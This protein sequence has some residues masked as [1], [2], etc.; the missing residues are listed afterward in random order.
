MNLSVRC[1][2][3]ILLLLSL[4]RRQIV[5]GLFNWSVFIEL[6]SLWLNLGHVNLYISSLVT[7]L[8]LLLIWLNVP[9]KWLTASG[10]IRPFEF[11]D[12]CVDPFNDAVLVEVVHTLRHFN[13]WKLITFLILI[14]ELINADPARV[15]ILE[16][17]RIFGN[18]F[19]VV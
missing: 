6:R 13:D 15:S 9:D 17:L 5:P 16:C 8:F 10:A 2:G 19:A 7:S 3:H 18:N 11:V 1:V 4:R 14:A 12:L